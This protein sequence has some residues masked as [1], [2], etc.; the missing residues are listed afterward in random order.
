MSISVYNERSTERNGLQI[1]G[2]VICVGKF[3]TEEEGI[4]LAND[5]EYGLGAAVYSSDGAQCIRVSSGN[6]H[7]C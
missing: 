5:T 2:P 6:A 4:A 7:L 1:F 3:E